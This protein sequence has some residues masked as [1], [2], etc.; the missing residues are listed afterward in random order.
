[1][2]R[3]TKTSGRKVLIGAAVLA[4]G[5]SSLAPT[6][7]R[8]AGNPPMTF[9]L[10]VAPGGG[11]TGTVSSDSKSVSFSGS[12]V[13]QTITVNLF[14]VMKGTDGNPANDGGFQFTGSFAATGALVGNFRGDTVGG[15]ASQTN[16]SAG[17]KAGGLSQSG[18]LFDRNG[19]GFFDSIGRDVT[20]KTGVPDSG[21]DPADAYFHAFATNAGNNPTMTMGTA[22]TAGGNTELLIGTTT[23]AILGGSGSTSLQFIPHLRSDGN[24]VGKRLEQFRVDG[25][26]YNLDGKGD[27][28]TNIA[29]NGT[30]P[31]YTGGAGSTPITGAFDLGSP[32]TVSVAPEPATAGL[33]V[34][35]A[36]GL[37]ARRRRTAK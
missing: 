29:A 20:F 16:N 24:L 36:A 28:V 31:N 21:Q 22:L 2:T 17:F 12:P 34:I 19:D 13:G 11:G 3:S 33:M 15:P 4:G 5:I 25:V 9:D 23:L 32:V 8:A 35:G 26:D 14:A 6:A 7:V 10:R 30:D 27:G 18:Y 37:L 1:M